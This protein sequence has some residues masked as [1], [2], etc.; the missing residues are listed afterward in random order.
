MAQSAGSRGRVTFCHP[1]RETTGRC[2][3]ARPG[4]PPWR[5]RSWLGHPPVAV[6]EAWLVGSNPVWPFAQV[7]HWNLSVDC[8]WSLWP[9][10][11]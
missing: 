2:I 5:G 4:R 1:P 3:R 7:W 11:G 9:L 6:E 8:C 10:R